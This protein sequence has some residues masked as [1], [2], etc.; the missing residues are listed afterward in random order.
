MLK[1]TNLNSL[2]ISVFQKCAGPCPSNMS[3]NYGILNPSCIVE[4]SAQACQLHPSRS[5]DYPDYGDF[6]TSKSEAV[7]NDPG[8]FSNEK[9]HLFEAVV[10]ELQID[11]YPLR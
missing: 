7:D 4:C 6:L 8:Q 9:C 11:Q 5:F 10:L 2:I 3:N 1:T